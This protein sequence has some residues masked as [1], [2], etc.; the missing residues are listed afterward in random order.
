MR[1]WETH[2]ESWKTAI[3][4]NTERTRDWRKEIRKTVVYTPCHEK[5]VKTVS[6][7]PPP[8]EC[9]NLKSF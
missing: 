8:N 1:K 2:C 7:S 5:K 3:R 6:R 4:E 9:F